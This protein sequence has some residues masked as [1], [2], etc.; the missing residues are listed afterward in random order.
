MDAQNMEKEEGVFDEVPFPFRPIISIRLDAQASPR[1][2]EARV[3]G[4]LRATRT[5][6]GLNR[7][8]RAARIRAAY[9][10]PQP[11][12]LSRSSWIR[13]RL[14]AG[15]VSRQCRKCEKGQQP[16]TQTNTL[17]GPELAPQ[18]VL[19]EHGRGLFDPAET[20]LP[21]GAARIELKRCARDGEIRG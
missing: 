14:G 19:G 4:D 17:P 9:P 7:E 13:R 12:H 18:T 5:A 11:R 10:L 20:R 21:P 1:S 3:Y 6:K 16:R 2:T 15:G 8:S